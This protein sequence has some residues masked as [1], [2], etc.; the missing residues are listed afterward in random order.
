M[1]TSKIFLVSALLFLGGLAM[2]SAQGSTFTYQGRLTDN[3]APATGHYDL[4]ILLFDVPQSGLAIAPPQTNVNVAV[5]GGLFAVTLD[6][7]SIVWNGAPRWLGIGVRTN[8]GGAFTPVLP[9]QPLTPSPYAIFSGTAATVPGGAIGSAQLANAIGLGTSN[10]N[11]RLDVY[12]TA[13]NTP[14][15]SLIGGTSQINA[16]G[17]DGQLKA[18]VEAASYGGRLTTWDELGNE[19]AFVG[20][21]TSAGGS[22]QLFQAN[23]TLSVNLDGDSTGANGGGELGLRAPD[24]SSAVFLS[25][26]SGA[27]IIAARNTDGNN[28]V[29]IDGQSTAGGGGIF[30]YDPNGTSTMELIGAENSTSGSQLLMKQANGATTIQLDAEAGAGGGGYFSLYEGDGTETVVVTANGAGNITLRQGDGSQGLGIS[31]NNGT[32]GGGISIFRDNGTFAG[33]FTVTDTTSRDGFFSLTRAN[34]TSLGVMARGGATGAGGFIQ[35]YDST[36]AATIT[37]NADQSSEGRITTQVLQITGGSD[38]SEQFDIAAPGNELTPGMIVCIDPE[39]PGR[40]VQSARAYDRTVAG[41]M[42]GAGGVKPGM[43]MGQPGTAAD[44]KHPVALSG[45]V[46]C[47]ADAS[48]GA[49]RPGDLLTTSNTPGHAMKVA[50]YDKAHGAI[51]GKAMSSLDQGEGLVLVLVSLQ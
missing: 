45:R 5:D 22:I 31:A 14:A 48:N 15:I 17:D 32:G 25:G 43:L 26:S 38:L 4:R 9:Y 11:G 10:I 28:R 20:S 35:L 50:D 29:F 30:V 12:R 47:Q 13:A 21:A 41:V 23:G 27:G 8:G 16:Y 18:K 6:F 39:H 24:G 42:S 2:A 3:G 40:L 49:I 37:L 34:S 36:G 51:I 19:T 46:Y 44:G 1:K 7:G 33:Q